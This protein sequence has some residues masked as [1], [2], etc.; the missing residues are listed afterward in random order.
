VLSKLD[1]P[2]I[3][4]KNKRLPFRTASFLLL[5]VVFKMPSASKLKTKKAAICSLL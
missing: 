5:Y 3:L 2:I 4:N 1:F